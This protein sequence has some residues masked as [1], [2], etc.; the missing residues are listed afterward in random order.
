MSR[1][2]LQTIPLKGGFDHD[3]FSAGGT[4]KPGHVLQRNGSNQVVVHS[5]E[6]G[7][8]AFIVAKECGLLGKGIDDAYASGDLAFVAIPHRNAVVQARLTGSDSYV[9]GDKLI[10]AGDGTLKKVSEL[11]SRTLGTQQVETATAA[12]S[13]SGSGNAT[14]TIT[15]AILPGSPLA[16]SVAVTNGDSAATWAGK[17]RTALAANATVTAFYDVGGS[18]TTIVLTARLA[19]A[20][21]TTLNIALANG[22][23]TGITTAAT[24]TNTTSGVAPV[25]EEKLFGEIEEDVDYTSEASGGLGQVRAY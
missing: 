22:T 8:G 9:V 11:G 16:I 5:V 7:D 10:S 23:S 4:F 17:V 2:A 15:S 25:L 1:Q 6:G 21:D 24:S 19:A 3:E 20:N 18:S 12:G 14:V 13:V